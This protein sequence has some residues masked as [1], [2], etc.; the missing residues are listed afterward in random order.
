MNNKKDA[1]LIQTHKNKWKI[2]LVDSKH[3]MKGMYY[4]DVEADS[5]EELKET[6]ERN[7]LNIIEINSFD[8]TLRSLLKR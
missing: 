4:N 8:D 3:Y 2:Y 6:I 7:D 1:I 5:I